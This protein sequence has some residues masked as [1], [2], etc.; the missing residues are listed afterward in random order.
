MR[1]SSSF[2]CMN[3]TLRLHLFCLCKNAPLKTLHTVTVRLH[4]CLTAFR[5]R[6]GRR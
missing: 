4:L 2:P 6:A 1:H 3:T 5:L